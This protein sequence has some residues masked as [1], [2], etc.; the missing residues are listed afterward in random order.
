MKYWAR[1]SPLGDKLPVNELV[2][3]FS[4]YETKHHVLDNKIPYAI[5]VQ[6][7]IKEHKVEKNEIE[8]PTHYDTANILS[9]QPQCE[10]T[11]IIKKGIT[12]D[13]AAK[14]LGNSYIERRYGSI[15]KIFTDGSKDPSQPYNG[16]AMVVPELGLNYGYKLDKNLTVYATELVAILKAQE[17]VKK[18]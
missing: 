1:S 7:L 6:D 2:Q 17:W 16:S 15:L 4:I 9:V 18:Q 8:T 11:K 10:L 13:K 14:R 3:D 5:A 12:S